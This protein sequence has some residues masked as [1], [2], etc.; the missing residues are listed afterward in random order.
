MRWTSIQQNGN[1]CVDMREK[2]V[3][4]WKSFGK[5][6]WTKE[7]WY[8]HENESIYLE[9]Y[10][11]IGVINDAHTVASRS[12]CYTHITKHIYSGLKWEQESSRWI[13]EQKMC[14]R[15]TLLLVENGTLSKYNCLP[16][17]QSLSRALLKRV[18]EEFNQL[19]LNRTEKF[20]GSCCLFVLFSFALLCV[21][22]RYSGISSNNQKIPKY[23]MQLPPM[24][25]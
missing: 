12:M 7:K 18:C 23:Q 15:C 3:L 11:V 19:F 13:C 24:K 1:E 25:F 9:L 8:G 17:I 22:F 4:H 20:G 10:A 14:E 2:I 6:N 16:T 21:C 5:S